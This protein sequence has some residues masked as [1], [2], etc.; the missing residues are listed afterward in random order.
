MRYYGKRAAFGLAAG[1]LSLLTSV[2][3]S[4]VKEIRVLYVTF[5]EQHAPALSNI[6]PEPADSGL[7]GARLG[8]AD[9]NTTGKFLKQHYQLDTVTNADLDALIRSTE[10]KVANGVQLVVA[11]MPAAELI[12]LS[13]VLE[14]KG[15]LIFNAGSAKDEL[16]TQQCLPGVLHTLPSRAMLA[17][18][19]GQWMIARRFNKWLL[20]SGSAE[21]DK[22]YANAIRRTAKRMGGKL[23][24][25]KVWDFDTD[26]RRTAQKE[27]PVFTQTKEYDIVLVADEHGDFGEYVPFNTWYPRPVAGTQGLT[28]VAWHRAVEQWGAAQLQSRFEKQAGRWMTARDYAAWVAVRSI[29]EAV[30]RGGKSDAK[31]VFDYVVSDN[32]Q[33]AA[34]KGR[35]LSFR[36]WSGQ[37]RQPIPLVHPRALVAQAP[38]EGYLHPKTELDTLGYDKPESQCRAAEFFSE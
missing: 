11:N 31:S 15:V 14:G 22:A 19:L 2:W 6:L 38:L 20:I 26:L 17:D 27:L 24:A 30:T 7:Q 13:G 5:E 34:F 9:S 37:L 21:G 12:A 4:E 32:F 23:V 1:L 16:R 28:P 8:I 10:E 29:A 18:A 36:K 3:A 33:L 35:K 25:D